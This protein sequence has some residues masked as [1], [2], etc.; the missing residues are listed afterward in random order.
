VLVSVRPGRDGVVLEV[1]DTGVGVSEEE[2][3]RLFDRLYRAPGAVAAQVQGA[4]LG[5]S[6]VEK[7]LHRH[8]GSV[9]IDSE[10]GVGTVVTVT[11]PAD[12]EA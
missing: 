4:G 1:R 11:L 5:L 9:T 12:H 6:I 2:R 7:I 8:G 3:Q 10:P